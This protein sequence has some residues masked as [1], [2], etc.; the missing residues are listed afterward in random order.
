MRIDVK[1]TSR[2][3]IIVLNGAGPLNRFR[4]ICKSI[5]ICQMTS[6]ANPSPAHLRFHADIT[7]RDV[8]VNWYNHVAL[9]DCGQSGKRRH[10]SV[11]PK[12]SCEHSVLRLC[13]CALTHRICPCAPVK[14]ARCSAEI[15]G[16]RAAI[17]K[18]NQIF[19]RLSTQS[20]V[21]RGIRFSIVRGKMI[22]GKIPF[23]K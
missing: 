12:T 2:R 23:G 22:L 11:S 3:L 1:S 18:L 13:R 15:V 14:P 19:L 17:R 16:G 21:C 9:P 6:L 7:R 10:C 4:L 8:A 20:R 5:G